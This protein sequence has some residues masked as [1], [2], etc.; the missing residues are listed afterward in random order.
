VLY[1]DYCGMN[2]GLMYAG[3]T[4]IYGANAFQ[5]LYDSYLMGV[6]LS[7]FML[8]GGYVDYTIR[9]YAGY[10]TPPRIGSVSPD[11]IESGRLYYTGYYTIKLSN[12][13]YLSA[14]E[15]FV[16]VVELRP[17]FPSRAYPLGCESYISGY[18][19]NVIINRGESFVS[20]DGIVWYDLY[21]YY[22]KD[23]YG[24]LSIKAI[25]SFYSSPPSGGG[26]GGCS[27]GGS[28]LG[29]VFILSLPVLFV[30]RRR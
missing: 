10:S 4:R 25:I 13:P 8:N 27:A 26:G 2:N 19:S 21:N 30:L 20:P 1:N 7:V 5:A 18:C 9:V 17:Q 29:L 28:S 23:G 6:V 16:V 12:P 3:S 14:G 11:A 22:S 24:N 15:P